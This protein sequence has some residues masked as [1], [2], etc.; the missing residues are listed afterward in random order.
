MLSNPAITESRIVMKVGDTGQP[1]TI[2]LKNHDT[3]RVIDLTGAAASFTLKLIN[4]N[5]TAELIVDA[6]ADIIDPLEGLVA[7]NWQQGDLSTAGYYTA[8]F[9]IIHSSGEI[10]AYPREGYIVVEVEP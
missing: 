1:L 10:E 8:V 4:N 2:Q 9:T 3:R 5:S 7:Y 6:P